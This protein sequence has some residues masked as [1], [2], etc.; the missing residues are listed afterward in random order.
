MVKSTIHNVIYLTATVYLYRIY[1]M[2]I[3]SN[4]CKFFLYIRKS[5]DEEKRQV[6]SLDAQMRE[7]RDFAKRERLVI[8]DI[9]QESRTAKEPGRPLFNRMLERIERGDANGIIVWDID[10]LYRNPVDEGRVRWMLQRGIIASIK[11]PT[12]SYFPSDAG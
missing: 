9:F 1:H 5:T 4:K 12:R 2:N 3:S 7:L 8:V 6:T 11:T 10:R